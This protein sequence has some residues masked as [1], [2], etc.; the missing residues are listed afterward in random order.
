VKAKQVTYNKDDFF[1]M[2]SCETLDKMGQGDGM[3]NRR[4]MQ[5]SNLVT[6]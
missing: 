3:Q 5:V 1:D 4:T 2:M 6:L